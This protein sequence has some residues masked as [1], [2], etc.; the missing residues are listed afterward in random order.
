MSNS[1]IDKINPIKQEA[2][3]Y[4]IKFTEKDS[5]KKIA[6]ISFKII[7]TLKLEKSY[8]KRVMPLEFILAHLDEG[9]DSDE[10][11]GALHF[12]RVKKNLFPRNRPNL[13]F[14]PWR[15]LFRRN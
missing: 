5:V 13:F 6:K 2:I 7:T 14:Q 1:F 8:Q 10:E 9:Y 15:R 3:D 4:F 12:I 11:E